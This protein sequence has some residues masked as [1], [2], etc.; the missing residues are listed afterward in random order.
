M[1]LSQTEGR[2]LLLIILK[3]VNSLRAEVRC[4][5]LMT[6]FFCMYPKHELMIIGICVLRSWTSPQYIHAQYST[7]EHIRGLHN[8]KKVVVI[9]FLFISHLCVCSK[10]YLNLSS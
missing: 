5:Y 2:K 1:V 3:A 7:V 6:V 4:W 10:V 9:P 8:K